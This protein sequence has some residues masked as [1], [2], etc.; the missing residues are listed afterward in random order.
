MTTV[1]EPAI[2]PNPASAVRRGRWHGSPTAS[3][4][5]WSRSS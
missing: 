5:A 1:A 4:A 2:E 3:A